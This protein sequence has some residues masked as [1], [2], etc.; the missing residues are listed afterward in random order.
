[1]PNPLMSLLWLTRH[2]R[3]YLDLEVNPQQANAVL[4]GINLKIMYHIWSII[5]ILYAIIIIKMKSG[6]LFVIRVL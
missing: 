6:S 3:I 5:Y 4:S 1:M 2:I